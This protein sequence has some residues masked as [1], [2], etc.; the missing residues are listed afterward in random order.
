MAAMTSSKDFHAQR[1]HATVGSARIAYVAQGSGPP[2]LFLHGVPLNGFHWRHVMA[3]LGDL[4]RCIALDLMGLGYSDIAPDQDVGF[5]A[6]AAMVHGFLDAL[7]I[8]Q[9]DLV[10][11][12][13][14]GAVAQIFAA[15]HPERVRSLALTNCDVH[16]GWPPPAIQ[17]LIAAAREGTLAARYD[18]LRREPAALR[19]A[20]SDAYAHPEALTDEAIEVYLAPLLGTPQRRDAFHRYWAAFDCRHTVAVAP[21]LAQLHAPALVVWGDAD[22]F[23]HRRWAHWLMH[24][25]PGARRLVEVSG[26]KLFFPEDQPEALAGPLRQFWHDLDQ[27]DAAGARHAGRWPA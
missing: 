6:Q 27:A 20:F 19:R 3:R 5:T 21:A 25:L 12:D 23:F 11:N 8:E 13:S 26:A 22:G 2:A 1:R 15:R 24:V 10:A 7:Q 18:Q 9:V 16:D 14:G 4:R 17:P